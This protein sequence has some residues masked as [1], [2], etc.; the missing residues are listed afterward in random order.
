MEVIDTGDCDLFDEPAAAPAPDDGKKPQKETK[1]PRVREPRE[2]PR[3][4]K[5]PEDVKKHQACM[6]LLHRYSTDARLGPYLKDMGF[7]LST[8]DLKRKSVEDLQELLERVRMCIDNKSASRFVADTVRGVCNTAELITSANERIRQFVNLQGLTKV[9]EA[10]ET[11]ADTVAQLTIEYGE[12]SHM[13]PEKRLLMIILTSG[14]RVVMMNKAIARFN[15]TLQPAPAAPAAPAPAPAP[16]A[17][18]AT[19]APAAPELLAGP[20][21][22]PFVIEARSDNA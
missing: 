19:P 5:S 4:R 1:Q 2:A 20:Q 22:Q 17:P 11:F 14:A 8:D 15:A 10:D 6:I 7:K 3:E 12:V 9:L 21:P 13:G 18:A 16:A